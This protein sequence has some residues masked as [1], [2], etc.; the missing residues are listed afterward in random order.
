MMLTDEAADRSRDL[1]E[2]AL[3]PA[4]YL[5]SPGFEHYA[6]VWAR[7]AAMSCLGASR[8]GDASLMAGVETTLRTLG[9][10]ASL[11]GQI[12]NAYWPERGYWDWG[13]AGT[14]DATAWFVIAI[15]EHV[16][17]TDREAIAAELWPDVERAL[18]WLAYQDVTGTGLV[19][20]PAGGD[21]MDSSLNRSGRVFHVNV[22]YYWAVAGAARLAERFDGSKALNPARVAAAIEG[23]FWP[24]AG[25]DLAGLSTAEYPPDADARFPH[26]L[27]AAEY[28]RLATTDRQHYLASVAYGRFIDRCDVLAHCLG[29]GSGLIDGARADLVLDYLDDTGC[30][31]PYPSRS[32][33]EP[34]YPDEPGSLLDAEADALQD[35][36]WRN[37][38]G[39]YH[40]GAVWPYVGAA[41]A[42]AASV[43]GRDERAQQLLEGVA[44]ANRLDDWGFHEWIQVPSGE[45][46]GARDQAWNAGSYLW[47]YSEI[48]AGG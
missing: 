28:D 46:L 26:P 17:A 29:I 23:L 30:A 27:A 34:M 16:A 35:P 47:A 15:A 11:Q 12:P 1:L 37:P 19:D 24:A 32:W 21:W 43:A 14:T 39:S 2:R 45:P 4:G 31:R 25:G 8:S 38:P 40:N 36:R 41:H 42:F 10:R 20:S 33:P 13:E 18:R 6:A 44:D 22:L 9:T 5:A 3:H 7:D 48:S